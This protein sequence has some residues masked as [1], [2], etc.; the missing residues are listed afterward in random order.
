MSELVLDDLVKGL[1][2]VWVK[3]TE[4]R[5]EGVHH[6]SAKFNVRHDG[7]PVPIEAE[8]WAELKND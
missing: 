4:D 7:T 6:Y 2:T 5:P 3:V 8:E 1:L